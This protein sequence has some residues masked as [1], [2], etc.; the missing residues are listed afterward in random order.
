VAAIINIG[1]ETGNFSIRRRRKNQP[2]IINVMM[3]TNTLQYRSLSDGPSG[4][5]NHGNSRQVE[6]HLLWLVAMVAAALT[7]HHT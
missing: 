1:G 3:T 6:L 5:A 2:A 4:N 7:N